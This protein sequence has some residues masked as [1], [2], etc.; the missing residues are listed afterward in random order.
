MGE[1][2]YEGAWD[3]VPELCFYEV[4]NAPERARYEIIVRNNEVHFT[5][6]WLQNGREDSL[7]FGGP[8]DGRLRPSDGPPDSRVSY[9]HINAQT[10]D[11]SVVVDN[12]EVA[13]ARRRV[14][15]DGS[16]MAVLQV[17]KAPDGSSVR[18]TQ[19][20]RRSD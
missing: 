16:L 7:A 2:S 1:R 10:L 18:L 17:N 13:Y 11:S 20:Y 19:L 4:G 8:I 6:S 15:D 9:T 12:V 3:L 5:I 14:S